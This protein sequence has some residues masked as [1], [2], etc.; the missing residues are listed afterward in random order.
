MPCNP[1]PC[2]ANAKCEERN[3]A[4]SC[5]CLPEYSGDPYVECRPECILNQDCP[6]TK[7]CLRNKCIDP[8]PGLCG[9]NA[10]CV[11]AMHVASW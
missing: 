5:T 9:A 4:A 2:G 7:T 11:V 1:S 8:C 3:N 10:E 6:Y